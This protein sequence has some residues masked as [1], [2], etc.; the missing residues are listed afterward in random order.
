[1]IGYAATVFGLFTF[2]PQAIKTW[3]TKETKDISLAMYI[4][5]WLGVILWLIYGIFLKKPPLIIVN[6]V[7]LILTSEVLILKMKYK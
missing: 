7:V 1:M 2:L 6:S 3:K 5:L 4:A